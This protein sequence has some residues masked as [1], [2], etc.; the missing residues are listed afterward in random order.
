[1]FY[2]CSVETSV[3]SR[4]T[5]GR[6]FIALFTLCLLGNI[7]L[8]F[9]IA[10]KHLKLVLKRRFVRKNRQ[11]LAREVFL[12]MKLINKILFSM[13]SQVDKN[14]PGDVESERMHSM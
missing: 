2:F 11:R 5:V 10:G 9:R 1:M 14:K 7:L 4:L 6:Y 8:I 13:V 12:Q 3:Q